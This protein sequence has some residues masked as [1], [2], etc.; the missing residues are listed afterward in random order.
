MTVQVRKGEH[1]QMMSP[2]GRRCAGCG[3]APLGRRPAR[4]AGAA[5]TLHRAF[6]LAEVLFAIF[7][8]GIG[9]I[10]LAA[11]FP[12][13]VLESQ[14][15]QDS[16]V[17]AMLARMAYD[18]MTS[19]PA[20]SETAYYD[21]ENL[22]LQAPPN[23]N[24]F[25]GCPL[26]AG[27]R[28][29]LPFTKLSE[30]GIYMSTLITSSKPLDLS[31]YI[32]HPA[33]RH[34]ATLTLTHAA[35]SFVWS[36]PYLWPAGLG[37]G[38][39]PTLYP[40]GGAWLD[41]SNERSAISWAYPGDTRYYWYAF[42]R[43]MFK[44]RYY[45]DAAGRLRLSALPAIVPRVNIVW[46]ADTAQDTPLSRLKLPRNKRLI[47]LAEMPDPDNDGTIDDWLHQ[48]DDLL[49]VP[50]DSVAGVDPATGSSPYYGRSDDRTARPPIGPD[51]DDPNGSDWIGDVGGS[52]GL[53]LADLI[54]AGTVRRGTLLVDGLGR[55]YS[56]VDIAGRLVRL[57][58]RWIVPDEALKLTGSVYTDPAKGAYEAVLPL[59]VVRDAI[60]VFPTIVV[61]QADMP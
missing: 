58:R 38:P 7:V 31:V 36:L 37:Q 47:P 55:V 5:A 30:L 53:T 16:T 43:Q 44:M 25:K 54:T 46:M 3:G 14:K 9:L 29:A 26:V 28:D 24:D 57:D 4:L 59:Y 1:T 11:A 27:F 21:D 40:F 45:T 23:N 60:A 33:G 2:G 19:V 18:Q 50:L 15:T 41:V 52:G 39:Q 56:V 49:P 34:P 35:N 10:M 12:V 42:Y 13:G 61:K 6:T 22:G 48:W 32:L 8:L 17:A 51:P 20:P